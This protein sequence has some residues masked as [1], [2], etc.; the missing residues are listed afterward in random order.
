MSTDTYERLIVE[1]IRGLTPELLSEIADFV[2]FVRKR[3][4][5]PQ[6]F[7]EEMRNALLNHELGQLSTVE[8]GHLEEE[9][10]GYESAY[11]LN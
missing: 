4:L 8:Q 5:D 2:F 3:T 1:G 6:E 7:E 10:I 9:F 11:P